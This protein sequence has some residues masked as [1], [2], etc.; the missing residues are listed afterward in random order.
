MSIIKKTV[1]LSSDLVEEAQAISTNFSSL[2]EAALRDY[3]HHY[4]VAKAKESFGK[5]QTRDEDSV[6]IVN[7]LRTEEGRRKHA[8]GSH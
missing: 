5:W 8:K 4:Y 3:L 7:E 6:T 1:S 2:V